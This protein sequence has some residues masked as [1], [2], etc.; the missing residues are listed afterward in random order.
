MTAVAERA[1]VSIT[2]VSHVM[3]LTR[4]VAAATA[5]LVLEAAVEVGYVSDAVRSLRNAGL[6]NNR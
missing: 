3:N 1:G 5:A 6:K 2:T 4:P